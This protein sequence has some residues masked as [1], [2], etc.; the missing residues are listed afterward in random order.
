[1]KKHNNII[2]GKYSPP[3]SGEYFPNKN[4]ADLDD[5]IGFYAKSDRIDVDKAVKAARRAYKKWKLAPASYRGKIILKAYELLIKKKEV[6]A[7]VETREMGK[8]FTETLGDV[9]EAIDTAFYMAGE[10]RRLFGITTPSELRNKSAYTVREPVGVAGIITPW[11]FPAAIPAWKIFPALICGN[12]VVFKPA[13]DT[14]ETARL[15]VELLMEAGIPDGVVNLV[16]G[17]GKDAGEAMVNHPDINLISFTGSTATG[18]H[19]AEICG[20]TL[21][22]CSLEM[23]GKNGQIILE[24]ADLDLAVEGA[25]WGSFATSGQRCTATSRII[26]EKSILKDF[27]KRFLEKTKKL[28]LGNGMDKKTDVGPIIN[29]SQLEK[30]THYVEVGIKKDKAKLLCGGKR[31]TGG[32][33][34]KGYFFEPTIFANGHKKM[35][36]A[37]EEIFGPV[38][39]IMPV[40][41][42]DEAMDVLNSTSY[43]LSSSI[44]TKDINKAL[45]ATSYAECGIV[46]V[47]GPTI[48]AECHLPFGGY[49][50]TGNG[51]RES[52]NLVLDFFTETKTIYIDY[53]GRLQKAQIDT[54]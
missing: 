45:K 4:P 41:N 32:K 7:E 34:K 26:I 36:I 29:N 50:N 31:A 47:N 21:K 16:Y 20:K 48:G 33:L 3:H 27:T 6:L 46:Y 2:D 35:T 8:I 10:G 37:Q 23:G 44:Y 43:G 51:H 13:P 17:F 22:R 5:T 19:I 38:T 25:L 52:G 24:D 49:K 15:F 30:I 9:Q 54:N 53:S 1:M 14:P 39:L 12:T 40:N 18:S 42:L 11:N 28:R